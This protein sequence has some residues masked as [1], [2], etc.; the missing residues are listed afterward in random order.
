MENENVQRFWT[1]L[2]VEAVAANPDPL[3]VE[4]EFIAPNA[5]MFAQRIQRY[6]YV[7]LVDR[8]AELITPKLLELPEKPGV[9][10]LELKVADKAIGD[11]LKSIEAVEAK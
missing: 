8:V 4:R 3:D 11:F 10:H 7:K 6:I 5:A 9:L 1:E 2:Q